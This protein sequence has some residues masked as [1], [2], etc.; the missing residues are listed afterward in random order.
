MRHLGAVVR[1]LLGAMD[2]RWHHGAAGGGVAAQLVGDQPTGETPL[3]LQEFPKEPHRGPPIPSR[4]H[5]DVEHVTVLVDGAP[6]VLLATI[7]RHEELVEVP[8]IA[9]RTAALPESS[10]VGAAEGA[11]PLPNRL[12]GDRDAALGEE[13][14]HSTKTQVEAKVDPNG[15][16]DDFGRESISVVARR[17]TVHPVTLIPWTST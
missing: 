4:L 3:F 7:D 8:R 11:A 1:I 2:H 14:F 9:Q 12:L 17:G 15:V 6:Q 13:V 10:R 5:Q 16:G